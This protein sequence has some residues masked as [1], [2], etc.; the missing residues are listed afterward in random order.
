MQ[1]PRHGTTSRVSLCLLGPVLVI[2]AFAHHSVCDPR[3]SNSTQS[4]LARSL[5]HIPRLKD[6]PTLPYV[7]VAAPFE[8][9]TAMI[10]GIYTTLEQVY[11]M[12]A[13]RLRL[14]RLWCSSKSLKISQLHSQIDGGPKL[15]NGVVMP[16]V[17]RLMRRCESESWRRRD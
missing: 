6:R 2:E 1:P 3:Q 10:G 9:D 17:F 4:L 7:R 12:R 8:A 16:N 11:N 15:E 14:L 5:H 13:I